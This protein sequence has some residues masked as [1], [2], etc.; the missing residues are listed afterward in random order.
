MAN[1]PDPCIYC[2]NTV[3]PR[4]E[5]VQCEECQLWQHRTCHTGITRAQYREAVRGEIELKWTCDLCLHPAPAPASLLESLDPSTPPASPAPPTPPAADRSA[6]D[7]SLA[8]DVDVSYTEPSIHEESSVVMSGPEELDESHHL[9]WKKIENATQR[10][11]THL[12][13]SLGFTYV[14]SK[15]RNRTTDWVCSIRNKNTKCKARVKEVDGV[16]LLSEADHCHPPSVGATTAC[17]VK[18]TI[19]TKGSQQPFATAHQLVKEAMRQHVSSEEPCPALPQPAALARA[20]NRQRQKTR[21]IH[22]TSLDFE[23]NEDAIP[24]DYLIGDITIGSRRHFVFSTPKQLQLLAAAKNWYVDG[25]FKLVREPF[26]Q[27]WS[28]H[29]FLKSEDNI[30][31]VPLLFAVMS[32]KSKADYKAVLKVVLDHL[33]HE[34]AVRSITADF[35]AGVWQAVRSL[36]RNV[37]LHGCVFHFTQAVWRHIQQLGLQAAYHRRSSTFE[38]CRRL[39]ALPFLPAEYIP[40]QFEAIRKTVVEGE[41]L[42]QLLDYM[43]QQWMTNSTFPV[44]SWSV[45]KRP[46][47]TNNDVE[48]YHNRINQAGRPNMNFYLLVDQLHKEAVDLPLEIQFL[49]R[50]SVLRFQGKKYRSTSSKIMKAWDDLDDGHISAKHLLKLA[51][52]INSPSFTLIE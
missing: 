44:A 6:P 30:K 8:E 42:L 49:A 29:A 3:R 45:F 37:S 51:S 20:A 50:G 34:P 12:T 26:K 19:R 40:T 10:G 4:Q 16:F 13:N 46:I 17:H 11:G 41:R 18:A 22:P 1:I 9:T 35:E 14:V 27:L 52:R 33:P 36:F 21:P 2:S 28:I 15:V 24:D 32:G 7:L 48:G 39:M 43:R 5:A 23:L 25:T 31:Q 38:F 47:R